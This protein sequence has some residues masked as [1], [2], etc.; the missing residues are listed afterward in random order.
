MVML[1]VAGETAMDVS[2]TTAAVTVSDIEPVT[3]LIVAVIV[4]VPAATPVATPVSLTLA[5]A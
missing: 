3:L 4:A 5:T 2:V 1:G